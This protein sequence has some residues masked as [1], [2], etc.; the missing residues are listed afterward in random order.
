MFGT[1][2]AQQILRHC[3]SCRT[4]L[5]MPNETHYNVNMIAITKDPS[6]NERWPLGACCIGILEYE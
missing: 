2:C 5:V 3:P 4:L 1:V 6:Q